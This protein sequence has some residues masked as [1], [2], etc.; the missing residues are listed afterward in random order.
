MSTRIICA[1]TLTLLSS[2]ASATQ[3]VRE[4]SAFENGSYVDVR[5]V[6]RTGAAVFGGG[7]NGIIVE[8]EDRNWEL[9]FGDDLR[10]KDLA[11]SLDGKSV[12]ATG[13]ATVREGS[14]SGTRYVL[15]VTHVGTA[16]P[17]ALSQRQGRRPQEP[18]EVSY[19][20]PETIVVPAPTVLS[21]TRDDAPEIVEAEPLG[22]PVEENFFGREPRRWAVP[23][24][25]VP[26]YW[27]NEPLPWWNERNAL[28]LPF[29][30]GDDRRGVIT[31]K[32]RINW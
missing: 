12:V 22:R 30:D 27:A 6:I 4:F 24:G 18:F 28:D 19:A 20:P 13:L 17:I 26:D 15:E 32:I 3:E 9:D 29:R 7:M 1:L 23:R 21:D 31:P 25:T 2:A 16:R 14:N 8:T 10:L 11:N 5:G